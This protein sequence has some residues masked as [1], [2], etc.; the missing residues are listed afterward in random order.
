METLREEILKA[1]AQGITAIFAAA[2]AWIVA[3]IR[4]KQAVI[5]VR[6]NAIAH[7]LAENTRVTKMVLEH[8]NAHRCAVEPVALPTQAH[9][10]TPPICEDERRENPR[11][12]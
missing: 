3:S 6:Q 10:A 4:S 2:A 12:D 8:L 7:Q 5:G 1:F 9:A 11:H